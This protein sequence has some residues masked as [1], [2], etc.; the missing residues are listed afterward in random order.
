MRIEKQILSRNPSS[1]PKPTRVADET[2]SMKKIDTTETS[3][4]TRDLEDKM[5]TIDAKPR[6]INPAPKAVFVIWTSQTCFTTVQ[7][8]L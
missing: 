7:I 2:T 4:K 3:V 5:T 6:V 8:Y 1:H